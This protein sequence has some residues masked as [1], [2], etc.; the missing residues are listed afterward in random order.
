MV[1]IGLV[2]G[3]VLAFVRLHQSAVDE[4]AVCLRLNAGEQ[5]LSLFLDR[6]M[7]LFRDADDKIVSLGKAHRKHS[8]LFDYGQPVHFDLEAA[9]NLIEREVDPMRLSDSDHEA[10]L[11]GTN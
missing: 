3:L 10:E 5:K 1:D 4:D 6:H 8:L 2:L 9:P 11:H 7:M